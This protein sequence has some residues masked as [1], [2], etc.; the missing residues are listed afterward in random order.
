[1]EL[2]CK[3][4]IYRDIEKQTI[5]DLRNIREKMNK[6]RDNDEYGRLRIQEIG[7]ER[8]LIEI[9]ETDKKYQ[10]SIK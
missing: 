6:T 4:I 2:Q 1:M 3:Y 9:R 8:R 10:E 7:I 5:A